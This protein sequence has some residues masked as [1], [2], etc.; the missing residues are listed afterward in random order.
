MP[1]VLIT[2]AGRRNQL[3]SCFR[4]SA[5]DLGVDLRVVATDISPR[6]SAACAVA[7]QSYVVPRCTDPAYIDALL[8][9]CQAEKVDLLVP[10]IDPE[11]T[12]ISCRHTEFES[13]GS[14]VAISS[15]EVTALANSK[16]ATCRVLG[17][18]GVTVPRTMWLQEYLAA[19]Q[20]LAWPIIAKP[21]A[22][23]ASVGLVR[24]HSIEDLKNLP[25]K[26]YVVQ[27]QC[28][29]L[30][31]TVNIFVDR[32]GQL[33][34]A[35]PHRRIEV[36]G[37]EVSKGRTERV[38]HLDEAARKIAAA[39]PGARGPLCFQ[40]FV[41]ESGCCTVFEINARFGGGYPLAH[42][43]GAQFSKWLL[44]ETIGLPTTA[45]NDWKPNVTMLR[46]DAAVFI[47]E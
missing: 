42:Q 39:F 3:I 33:R 41:T 11:L 31:Y 14:R 24:P 6:L 22:G 17:A 21:N 8:G 37:G 30:E 34:C 29:G 28:D 5:C 25:A 43:A 46:Y 35:V 12:P 36:R 13:L 38:P 47:N 7:D 19:P 9:I 20:L 27:E 18:S 10:T 15:P 2:S 23:S 32:H 45:N 26:D 4:A 16:H 44:E 1:T 40:A